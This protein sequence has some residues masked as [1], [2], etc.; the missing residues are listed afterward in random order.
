MT[1]LVYTLGCRL[2]QCESEALMDAFIKAGFE[3]APRHED[4]ELV[5]VNTCTVTSKAE[6]KARRMIRL[7]SRSAKAVVV[8]GCYAE[9]DRSE[10]ERLG[11]HVHVY[12]L[13]EKGGLMKLPAYLASSLGSFPDINDAIAAF[14][15]ENTD[16]FIFDASSFSYHCRAYLKIQDGCDNSCAYCRTTIARGP[17][18][19]LDAEE[20]LKRAKKIERQGLHEIMLTGV[21][22]TMY[23]HETG[24]LGELTERLLGE[25]GPDMRIRFSS[26]EADH[27]DDRLLDCFKDE[28]IFPHFHLPIQ[29]ASNKVLERVR[30]K[31]TIEHIEYIIERMREYKDDP[32]IACDIIAGLP[33][34][35]DEAFQVTYDFLSRTGFAAMHVFPYSP[36]EGTMLWNAKDRVEERVRDE[37]AE[38]LRSLSA[39]LSR[40]YVARQEGRN[41]EVIVEK[42]KG[43]RLYGT[44][45]NYLKVEIDGASGAKEGDLLKAR[46]VSISPLRVLVI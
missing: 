13:K 14:K 9:M 44:S 18:V 30:R 17:S 1:V 6:Q 39:I 16:P 3:K 7:Y 21:N 22:L 37:R 35:D 10:I 33:G 5:I 38:K 41:V 15:N 46:I 12:G 31:Y 36:R 24:G 11:S 4:A 45:G 42:E 29:S 8:T 20:V 26:L 19:S 2:N 27:V 23:N 43:G 28:R 25:L 34:E 40:R 32:F